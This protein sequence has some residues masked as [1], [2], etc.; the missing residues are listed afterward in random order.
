MKL[1]LFLAA[2]LLARPASAGPTGEVPALEA[3]VRELEAEIRRLR[4]ERTSLKLEGALKRVETVRAVFTACLLPRSESESWIN[5]G[6]IEVPVADLP[7][8]A[9]VRESLPWLPRALEGRAVFPG[10]S[11]TQV[12]AL[13][14]EFALGLREAAALAVLPE[15]RIRVL[16]DWGYATQFRWPGGD[17]VIRV[18]E[19]GNKREIEELLPEVVRH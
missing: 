15:P 17:F 14:T 5:P 16:T 9:A 4:D 2:A 19:W 1:P 6:Q 12:Q 10:P 7:V 3:R 18:L 13:L 11:Q 8:Y